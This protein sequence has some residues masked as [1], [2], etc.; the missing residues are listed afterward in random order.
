M[1]LRIFILTAGGI[2]CYSRNFF[3]QDSDYTME[4]L[5][6]GFLSALDGFAQELKGG[7]IRGLNFKNFNFFYEKDDTYDMIFVI[8]VDTEDL[9]EEAREKLTLMKNEFIRRY[10]KKL[11]NFSGCVSDFDDFNGFVEEH[12]FIPPKILLV[13]Q[14]G[15]GKTTIMNLFPGETIV[16]LDEDMNERIQKTI[17]VEGLD[18]IKKFNLREIDLNELVK[19]SKLYQK[20][21]NTVDVLCIITNSRGTNLGETKK[22]YERLEK[23]IQKPDVY[24]IANYQDQKSIAFAPEK[25]ENFFESKTYGFSAIQ[26]NAKERMFEIILEI[27]QISVINKIKDN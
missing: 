3:P 4:D 25:I 11:E 21:L 26:T 19:K 17:I 27:L 13:G 1:I 8:V 16:E 10:G 23:K 12:I 15:V 5:I 2:T 20:Y 6:G 18:F 22:L 24:I 7:G 9:E 14:Q